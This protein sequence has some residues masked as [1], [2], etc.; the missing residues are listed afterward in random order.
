MVDFEQAKKE[1][2]NYTSQYDTS[3][4]NI[5]RKI[6]HSFRVMQIS[7]KLAQKLNLTSEQV[8][9]ATLIGLL[10]DIG[11]FTQYTKCSTFK[12]HQSFDHGDEGVKILEENSYI[13][14]YIKEDNYDETIKKAIKNHNKYQ[15]EVNGE[16][17]VFCKLIKD[18]DKLDIFYE[19]KEMFWKQKNEVIKKEDISQ[20]VVN[21][22]ENKELIKNEVKTSNVD[23][24]IGIISFLYDIHFKA[25]LEE[26]KKENYINAILDRFE[27]KESVQQQINEIKEQADKYINEKIN[28]G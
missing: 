19:A 22:I 7:K 20:E 10:H 27:Y 8:E 23:H 4:S 25:T 5:Q 11:R 17:A 16:D 9:I 3:N 24:I 14:K 15:L 13:R 21:Q 6:G 12:D 1:F 2:I 28:E 18:A 26:I